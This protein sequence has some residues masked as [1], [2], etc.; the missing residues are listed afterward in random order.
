MDFT[1]NHLTR[2]MIL[3][4]MSC[5]MMSSVM[6]TAADGDTQSNLI[7][8]NVMMLETRP[9]VNLKYCAQTVLQTLYADGATV[10]QSVY[11]VIFSDR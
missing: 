11:A 2:Y 10:W 8:S 4:L 9:C 7:P 1:A 3:I 6:A 5:L